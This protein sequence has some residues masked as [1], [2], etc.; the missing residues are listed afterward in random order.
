MTLAFVLGDLHSEAV[1]HDSDP[2][3][4]FQ[5]PSCSLKAAEGEA[6]YQIPLESFDVAAW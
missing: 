1:T 2:T 6:I 3:C 4:T 5:S